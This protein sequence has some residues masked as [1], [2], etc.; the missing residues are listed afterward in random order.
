M[1]IKTGE[2]RELIFA[3]QSVGGLSLKHYVGHGTANTALTLDDSNPANIYVKA[4]LERGR[5]EFVLF[6]DSLRVLHQA[7]NIMNGSFNLQK[8]GASTGMIVLLAAV[9]LV[10]EIGLWGYSIDFGSAINLSGEDKLR[11][12]VTVNSTSIA[13]DIDSSVSYLDVDTIEA[14]GDYEFATPYI[15]TYAIT[16]NE[17]RIQRSLGDNVTDVIWLNTDKSDQLSAS[18]IIS[19]SSISSKFANISDVYIE[20]LSK[21]L[22]YYS[23]LSEAVDR[24]QSMILYHG[25][26]LDQVAIDMQLVSGNVNASKNW[27][28]VRS[29]YIDGRL[30]N[31]ANAKRE[32]H[33]TEKLAKVG[34]IDN[35]TAGKAM[36]VAEAHIG[37]HR[38]SKK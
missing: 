28:V 27:L 22:K 18:G 34:A 6:Q 29:H 33:T 36:S 19:N 11:V 25:N 2:T 37:K 30:V 38:P 4:V 20:L 9:T 7:T 26:P 5:K 3:N 16:A 31:I 24:Y 35:A 10:K 12:T 15:N 17:S 23:A 8:V 14:P 13:S 1:I 21:Q 32:K